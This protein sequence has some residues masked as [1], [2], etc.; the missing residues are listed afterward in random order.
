MEYGEIRQKHARIRQKKR[1]NLILKSLIALAVVVIVV[2]GIK[3][4]STLVLKENNDNQTGDDQNVVAT[5]EAI[6]EDVTDSDKEDPASTS[7]P[8]ETLYTVT[9]IKAGKALPKSVVSTNGVLIDAESGK[10]I[11]QK[12]CTKRI[13]P[14]SMTK[15][16]T[17]Y[18]AA[19]NIK[20]LDK[21]LKDKVKITREITDYTYSN[22]CSIVGFDVDEKVTVQDLFYGTILPSGADAALAL[23][24]YV[25]GSQDDFVKLM[26]AEL[27]ELGIDKTTHFTNC[28][29]LYDENHYSTVND[30]A[31]ILHAAVQDEF[32]QKVLNARKYTTTKNSKHKD[33][34]LISNW[35]LRRIE[36][37]YTKGEVLYAKTGYVVQSGS[38]AASLATD[39]AGKEYICVTV[40]S[41]SSWRCIYDHVDIYSKYLE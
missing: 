33:G 18:V 25:A 21:H 38:C 36:D 6:S 31:I 37:K 28:V 12:G 17:V 19:K 8:E 5:K 32:C 11:A 7:E 4:I 20:D 22:G 40:G 1:R 27:K 30:I 16:L 34:L 2:I 15:I 23:A 14:A 13:T 10:V 24:E 41:E 3:C 39:S 35:F 9:D 26:N 29:G